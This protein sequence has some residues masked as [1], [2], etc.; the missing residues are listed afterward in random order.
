MTKDEILE[1]LASASIIHNIGSNYMITEEYKHLLSLKTSLLS[2][3]SKINA[4][5]TKKVIL[6]KPKTTLELPTELKNAEGPNARVTALL[7]HCGVKRTHK[8]NDGNTYQLRSM[9][10]EVVN[11]LNDMLESPDV[12]SSA[13]INALQWYY[14]TISTP[15]SVK[16][17][18]LSGELANLYQDQMNGE[19]KT[20]VSGDNKT[21]STWG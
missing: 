6:D 3:V 19:L 13:F 4:P 12:D 7:N 10:K 18:V 2:T 11:T 5:S 20:T 15:M 21:N 17:L 16:K 9:S 8:T 1:K 14:K